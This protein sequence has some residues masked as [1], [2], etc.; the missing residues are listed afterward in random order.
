[1]VIMA[2]RSNLSRR[3]LEILSEASLYEAEPA[4]V[5]VITQT[6]K[7]SLC[8]PNTVTKQKSSKKDNVMEYRP[9]TLN[10]HNI[11]RRM[12]LPV[13]LPS[14]NRPEHDLLLCNVPMKLLNIE[15][16]QH[17]QSAVLINSSNLS[18]WEWI[19]QNKINSPMVNRYQSLY[20]E[21]SQRWHMEI[22]IIHHNLTRMM[23]CANENGFQ[24]T[25]DDLSIALE[26]YLQMDVD[27]FN[28]KTCSFRSVQSTNGVFCNTIKEHVQGRYV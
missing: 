5:S 14:P 21:L 23:K 3:Q 2:K 1:M 19:E 25:D 15:Q 24:L 8:V 7:P 20:V 16:R 27:T 10:Q 18:L 9:L 12:I 6:K 17:R 26:F 4:I 22:P 13:F 28:L 11:G